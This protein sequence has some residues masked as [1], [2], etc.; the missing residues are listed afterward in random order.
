MKLGWDD[1]SGRCEVDGMSFWLRWKALRRRD[2]R[3]REI[4]D[5]LRVHLEMRTE[6]NLARGMSPEAA[7]RDAV[8]RF[9]NPVVMKEEVAQVDIAL[10]VESLLRDVRYAWRQLLNH[11]VFA[12]T[13]IATIAL[14]MG[15]TVG[16]FS[17]V[18]SVLLR[19]LPYRN[20]E[21]LVVAYG[22]LRRRSASDLP[23]SMPDF[24]DLRRG[25]TTMFEDFAGVF[26]FA[27]LL[28]QPDGREEQVHYASITTNFFHLMG[29]RIA[30]GR[31]FSDADG[32]S[33]PQPV[34]DPTKP[35]Q[36][37][38][39][40]PR[41]AILS[42]A[43]WQ[44]HFGGNPQVLG[45][46]LS[47]GTDNSP[48]IVGVAAPGFEL[49][50]PPKSSVE[51][52]PDV[53]IAQRLRYD[54][55][56]RNT[57]MF[58]VVGRLKAGVNLENAQSELERISAELR[59]VVPIEQS[60]DYHIEMQP[61]HA[62]LVAGLRPSILA[63][64]AAAVFL[65]LIA[66][67][68][69]ANLFL[70]RMSLRE[71]E[72]AVRT[73]LGGKRWNLIR[74]VLTEAFLLALVGAALGVGLAWWG[75]HEL[76]SY[77]AATQPLL[78]SIGIDPTVLAVAVLC[79]L[80]A[81]MLFG[82]GPALYASR[83][84]VTTVLRTSGRNSLL[85]G[86]RALRTGVII[87]EIALSFSLLTG[88]GLMLRSFVALERIDPGFV[89][90]GLYTFEVLGPFGPKPEQRAAFTREIQDTL[91]S[92]PGVESV[93]SGSPFPLADQYFPIRWG[94][95]SAL[96]DPSR[97]QAV[98][99]VVVLPGYFKTM[100]TPLL[101]GRT[102]TEADNL[103]AQSLVVIDEFL[104]AK[105]FPHTSAIGKRILIRIR[106]PEPEWVEVIGVVAHERGT[107]LVDPGREQVYFTDGFLGHGTTNRWAI[108]GT[109]ETASYEGA[110]RERITNLGKQLVLTEMKP[111]DALV[112][113]A[114]ATTRL[115]F[116][117]IGA[118]ACI[119]ALLSALGIYGVLATAVR[120]RTAEIGVRL[121]LGAPRARI[122]QLIVGHGLG[123]GT[124]GIGI[125][126][127]V[128]LGLTHWISSLL[129][130]TKASDPVTFFGI[131][132]G[133]FVIVGLASWLP[134]RR[135]ALINPVEALRSE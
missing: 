75:V 24:Q 64:M 113:Q 1:A 125:G 65:L 10:G 21:R 17:V 51:R 127:L 86:G 89:A 104:A 4:E 2:E 88:A 38:R 105:A 47:G 74:Q 110:V 58:I 77:A 33:A 134:A 106:T 101:A 67:A 55:A 50:F 66:C 30:L 15:A 96:S 9:G 42:Y 98:D 59:R 11:R 79:G 99:S 112:E 133:F 16:V 102:F 52:A 43:Y 18:H 36:P 103:T 126:V 115:S 107:S 69:V 57:M 23:L 71:R 111:M 40:L 114:Q 39:N 49:L 94:T 83:P 6:S 7:R 117:L 19:P 116:A 8:L 54:S 95:E 70:V 34:A 92:I 85:G 32:L 5:E 109:H 78:A 31:D 73:A 61:M 72:L 46:R 91:S 37:D 76:S 81:A 128:A 82:I 60:S 100:K 12:V 87:A 130:E 56:D 53:W 129:V 35:A 120:Q 14:G 84:D 63:L 123:L 90:H 118:F 121:A 22:D 45:Q 131:T 29:G 3:N 13:V 20:P 135:A 48:V 108:R 68:N 97:Y 44:R 27:D 26:T 80:A 93:T 25:A 41:V 62:Y 132:I 124:A 28:P 119:A 122:F